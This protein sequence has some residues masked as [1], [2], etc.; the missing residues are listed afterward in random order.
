MGIGLKRA[1]PNGL[2]GVS[3]CND[4]STW[5]TVCMTKEDGV[6]LNQHHQRA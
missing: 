1:V 6:E 4:F 2:V 5:Q 3:M